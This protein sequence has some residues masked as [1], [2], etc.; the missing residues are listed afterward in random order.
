MS[1]FQLVTRFQ[2]AGDQPEAIRQLVEGIEAGL[3]HQTLLG[4]T[5]SGKTFSIA[6][7]IQHVQRPTLVLAP[8]KTLAAQLYGEFKAFFPNNA[9]EYFVSYYDYYQPEAYV[10]SSDTFI[11]KDASINDHI[12][13]MRLSAT[14]A[15]LE[16]RDAIIVTTVSCIYGLGSPETYLKMVLHVDR[17]DKLDQRALLRRL[18]D[19]Q[20]TR[21]EMDFARATF[22]VRGDVIDIFPAESD[23]EAIRIE[24]FDDEVENIAAFDPLTGE[25]FR[26]L[27]RFTFYPKSHYVTPRETLLEAVEGIKEELKERL[28]YLHKANKL[29][30][31]QRLEQRT[32]FDL[33]LDIAGKAQHLLLALALHVQRYSH[34]RGIVNANANLLDR[35]NQEIVIAIAANDGRKQPHHRF[36]PDRRAQ[37]VPGA[38]A[39]NAHVDVAAEVRVPQMHR[40]QALGLGDL[41][42]KVIGLAGIAHHACLIHS[43]P[44]GYERT[45]A[46]AHQANPPGYCRGTST[47]RHDS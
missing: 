9:V 44:E 41:R 13:Q 10:P 37:V 32:R 12:E 23:L 21:N 35:S 40:R 27:P 8:N 33:D 6:N 46:S 3:S 25:V 34:E 19:L 43:C 14:K 24:L 26:K 30:E 39:G 2:P 29:V 45:R 18:A 42:Q 28:E 38:I 22:R 31:A 4:V 11:E 17:G 36:A 47:N 15:L 1:E 16:R 5:G 20:Y 7:V